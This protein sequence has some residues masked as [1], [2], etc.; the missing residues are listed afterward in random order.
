M[1]DLLRHTD[2]SF[3]LLLNG[4]HCAF[5]DKVFPI[6][7]EF[8]AWIPLFLLWFWLLYKKFRKKLFTVAFCIVALVLLTDQSANLVKKT[9]KR[10]RPS[11]NLL[12]KDKVH[13][14]NDYRGGEYGFVSNHAANVWGI[15]IFLFLLLRPAKKWIILSL[16]T[17]AVFICYT[18]IYLGVHY[19]L[20]IL[21]GALL[22][23][24]IGWLVSKLC[25][26]LL[27]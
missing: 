23:G 6:L 9:V 19:P 24:C 22:G 26:K 3:F 21:G 1:L 25:Y 18:R 14:V 2:T 7:T 4:L 10:Y 16:F 11:H 15:A 20:D 17:W 12:I 8:W 27:A 5:C 13:V